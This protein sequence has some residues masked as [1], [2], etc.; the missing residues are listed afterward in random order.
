MT[1]VQR[2]IFVLFWAFAFFLLTAFV[3]L[4]AVAAI[5]SG[6]DPPIGKMMTA[7]LLFLIPAV[8]CSLVLAVVTIMYF[9]SLSRTYRWMGFSPI[10]FLL[11]GPVILEL[12]SAIL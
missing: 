12:S 11:I 7:V 6:P 1:Q 4:C 2:I 9:K 3:A 10:T 8:V 5:D